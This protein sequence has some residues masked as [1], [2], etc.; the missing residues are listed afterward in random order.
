MKPL[1]K[2]YINPFG[3]WQVS[4]EGDEEG[5]TIKILG[6]Y[7][8][9]VDKIALALANK[10]YY[11]LLFKRVN[12]KVLDKTPKANK[13]SIAFDIDSGTWDLPSNELVKVMQEAFKDRPN[14]QVEKSNYFA[15]FS[16]VDTSLDIETS[17]K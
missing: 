13:V 5:K 12:S 1:D 17:E 7:T 2:N 15:S 16:I 9:F 4:T 8:G 6:V 14:I 3:I 11:S 10:A